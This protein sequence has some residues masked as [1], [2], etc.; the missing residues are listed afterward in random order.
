MDP[1]NDDR[2]FEFKT[3]APDDLLFLDDAGNLIS[4]SAGL[5]V[6]WP[7]RQLASMMSLLCS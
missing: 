6:S 3:K 4:A 7:P 1:T 2:P 5:R